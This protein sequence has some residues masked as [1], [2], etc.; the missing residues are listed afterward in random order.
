ML[1]EKQKWQDHSISQNGNTTGEYVTG[2]AAS[3]GTLDT[4]SY[5][6]VYDKIVIFS[7]RVI[8][9]TSGC[10]IT[11][12]PPLKTG[13]STQPLLSRGNVTS[14]AIYSDNPTIIITDT[15]T[16]TFVVTGT[17]MTE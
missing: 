6:Y 14:C 8:S 9:A 11:G 4:G 13:I 15:A 2:F 12:M 5:I 3:T 1:Y 10:R 17:Y 7:I 16:G